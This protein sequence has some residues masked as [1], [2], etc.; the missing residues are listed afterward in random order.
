MLIVKILTK[1][2]SP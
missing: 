2:K 1:A